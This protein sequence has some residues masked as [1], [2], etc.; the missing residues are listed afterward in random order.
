MIY[1]LY[2]CSPRSLWGQPDSVLPGHMF[3][4]TMID[5]NADRALFRQ[6]ADQIRERISAGEFEPGQ[7]LP[8][9]AALG[10]EYGLA[11]TAVR[12]AL[13]L[14]RAEGLVESV[15]GLG[16][17]VRD[18]PEP[19]PVRLHKGDEATVTLGEGL[20]R[21]VVVRASGDT[22]TYPADGVILRPA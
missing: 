8:S 20:P 22:E 19:K 12:A 4:S 18:R 6:L 21:V 14:L 2:H 16:S 7:M 3:R 5:P 15:R 10:Q 9:E 1:R 13:S 11:R 17:V